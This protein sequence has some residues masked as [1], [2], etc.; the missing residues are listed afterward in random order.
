[1]LPDRLT[2]DVEASS[3]LYPGIRVFCMV[4]TGGIAM[5]RW[6]VWL[7]TSILF[8]VGVS[9][10]DIF[11][12]LEFRRADLSSDFVRQN[13]ALYFLFLDAACSQEL[14]TWTDKDWG[15]P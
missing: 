2:V 14:S 8:L 5:A 11:A 12:N 1:M 15:V 7:S 10:C 6:E 3:L 4:M 13:L 9:V